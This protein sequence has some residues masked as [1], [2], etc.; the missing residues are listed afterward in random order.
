MLYS[1]AMPVDGFRPV[2]FLM[3]V[4]RLAIVP[5]VGALLFVFREQVIAIAEDALN[6]QFAY[7]DTAVHLI[8]TWQSRA[9]LIAIFFLVALGIFA[10]A[11]AARTLMTGLV[12][13]TGLLF[14]L[15]TLV[16]RF[17]GRGRPWF[18]AI[19]LAGLVAANAL[20]GRMLAK[21]FSTE[22]FRSVIRTILFILPGTELL[23]PRVFAASFAGEWTEGECRVPRRWNLLSW[24]LGAGLPA[25]LWCS[26][27]SYK[28]LVPLER[29]WFADPA[30][31]LFTVGGADFLVDLD[32]NGIAYDKAAQ[33]IIVAGVKSS[34][35][36]A[37]DLKDRS[38][39][40]EYGTTGRTEFIDFEPERREVIFYDKHERRIKFLDAD[41]L[42]LKRT[43]PL[44]IAQGGSFT[45][46]DKADGRLAVGSEATESG[47]P[48][49][50]LELE[51]G[52]E[53]VPLPFAPGFMILHPQQP[54]LYVSFFWRE[55]RILRYDL[56]GLQ[57]ER[58][59]PSPPRL[60]RIDFD[61][62][63][64]E[65]LV[66]A[67]LRS[68]LLRYDAETLESKGIIPTVFGVRTH[69]VDAGRDLVL[70]GSLL[71]NQL[72]VVDLATHERLARYRL[73]P[74]LRSIALDTERGIAY[75][76]SRFG[77]FEVSY[78]DR[79]PERYRAIHSGN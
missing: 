39:I 3:W 79:L 61:L 25:V 70:T 38:Q 47:K 73:G 75:V 57:L 56:R 63:R 41:Q 68:A 12:L 6:L 29:Q 54:I 40:R 24:V 67:P 37:I 11:N 46:L 78:L 71:T 60:D 36:F 27:F 59:V 43:I 19:P 2:R 17:A 42:T 32:L 52:R 69:A 13:P 30:V 21:V 8:G 50:V 33:Q 31:K 18:W 28:L 22:K 64:G 62:K 34:R 14:I 16:F 1:A 58:S 51:T 5:L 72:E 45:V 74:H 77:L 48:G 53:L 65:V 7:V 55:N 66:A 9:L 4:V 35:I 20:S 10:W 15:I 49:A 44:E 26:F 76:S 23:F